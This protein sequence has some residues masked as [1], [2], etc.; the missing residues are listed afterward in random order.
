MGL[1]HG[2]EITEMPMK[3]KNQGESRL[4]KVKKL[5]RLEDEDEHDDE[6]DWR[7]E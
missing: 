4:L 6:G 3:F 2:Y 1:R 7:A 5:R